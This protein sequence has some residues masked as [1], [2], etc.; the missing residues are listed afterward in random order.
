MR[1]ARD[2][3]MDELAKKVGR[4]MEGEDAFDAASVLA[5]CCVCAIHE[6]ASDSAKKWR[7]MSTIISFMVATLQK[8]EEQ[9]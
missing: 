5:M 8:S 9:S 1:S 3:Y 7:M 4:L 2:N 6:V